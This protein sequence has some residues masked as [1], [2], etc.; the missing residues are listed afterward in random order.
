MLLRYFTA[1]RFAFLC[2]LALPCSAQQWDV[3]GQAA[4]ELSKETGRKLNLEFEQ[5]SRFEER[6]GTTFGRDPDIATGLIRTRFGLNYT[7]V[8]WLK[9]SGMAQDARAPW[10]GENAP[11]SVRDPLDWHEGYIELFPA[12]K[13]GFGLLAGRKMLNYG[14]GRLLGTPEW[15]PLSRTYDQARVYWRRPHLRL[16]FLFVSPVKIRLGEFNRPVLGD[17]VWGTYNSFPNFY[18][19]HLLEVYLLRREQNRPGGFTGGT[20]RDGTDKIGHETFGFRLNGPLTHGVKY[21]LEAALQHGKVGPANHTAEAWFASLSR[22]WTVGGHNLEAITEYKFASGTP[23]PA[24][25]TRSGTFDQLYPANH[26][27]F[28]HQDIFGWRNIHNARSQATFG[29]TKSLSL[30][31]MYNNSWLANVKD[32]LYNGQGRQ[33]ARSATGTAGRHI[34]QGT[35]LFGAYK[36]GHFTL[37]AGYGHFFS[38]E[39]VRNA[40]PGVGPTYLYI[41]HSYSL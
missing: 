26:D 10:Y 33:I 21:S 14:E 29:I 22:H 18:K 4:S 35:D 30:N 16:E 6:T 23:N 8:P 32:A 9:L 1:L 11:N 13:T 25:P 7:P 15:A 39:F 12:A 31:F 2:L 28:G 38:G 27:K 5:R 3:L 34:G 20:T 36:H 17:R 24:D 40:T 19:S 41:F 37:G